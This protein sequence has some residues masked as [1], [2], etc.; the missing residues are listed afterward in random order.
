MNGTSAPTGK[1]FK[2]EMSTVGRWK[3]GVM[4]EEFLFWDN[5]MFMKQIGLV[6]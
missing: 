4:V 1:P 2:L 6:Q 5:P 3:D